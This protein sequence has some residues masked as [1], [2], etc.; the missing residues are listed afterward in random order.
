VLNLALPLS[1]K[2][3]ADGFGTFARGS[4]VPVTGEISRFFV[5]WRQKSRRTDYD[6]SVLFLDRKFNS[7]GQTSWTNLRDRSGMSTHSGD[8]VEAPSGASE[9][10]DIDL[11]RVEFA[12][13]HVVP[14][15]NIYW[16]ESFLDVAECFFGFMERGRDQRGKPFE[17]ATVRVKSDLYGRGRVAL[18]LVFSREVDGT[19]MARWLNLYL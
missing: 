2:S 3:R 5:H 14:Q 7:I 10:I 17:P 13:T 19:W 11:A 1:D 16:G 6:L 4:V 9:F 15:V 12:V 18:P 8:L